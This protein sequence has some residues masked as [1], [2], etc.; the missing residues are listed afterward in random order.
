MVQ[1]LSLKF[2][3]TYHNNSVLSLIGSEEKRLQTFVEPIMLQDPSPSTS[4]PTLLDFDLTSGNGGQ[5]TANSY[6]QDFISLLFLKRNQAH[7]YC[8]SAVYPSRFTTIAVTTGI[9]GIP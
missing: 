4:K 6:Y 3:I 2:R 7:S 9:V 1:D 5:R 8:F